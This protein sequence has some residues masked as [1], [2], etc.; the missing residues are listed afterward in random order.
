VFRDETKEG[1]FPENLTVPG[2]GEASL[3]TILSENATSEQR[4]NLF[5]TASDAARLLSQPIDGRLTD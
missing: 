2:H 4:W 1:R 5:A 3:E